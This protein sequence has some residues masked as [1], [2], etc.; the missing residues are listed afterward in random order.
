MNR[1][2]KQVKVVN[3]ENEEERAAPQTEQQSRVEIADME[4]QIPIYR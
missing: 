4:E 3:C 1:V 2:T